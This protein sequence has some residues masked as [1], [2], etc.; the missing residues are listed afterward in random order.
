MHRTIDHVLTELDQVVDLSI[1]QDDA[2]GI[3]A[4]V[5]RRTTAEIK[6]HIE[7]RNF[8]DNERMERFDVVFA[9][10]YLKAFQSWQE[11]QTASDPWRISFEAA[12]RPLCIMQHL[13][14]GMNAHI[15][16]DL[17]LAAAEVAPGEEIFP[18]EADFMKVNDVL[19]SLIDEIQDRIARVS[20]LMFV[21]DRL[22]REDERLAASM[23][24]R[25]RYQA[26]Q[27]ACQLAMADPE[28]KTQLQTELVREVS[29]E[30]NLILHPPHPSLRLG[31]W[32][33]RQFETRKLSKLL[34]RLSA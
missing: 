2:K 23:I 22:S 20:P 28:Q 30:G 8:E 3:F 15:N 32:L 21:V 1:A 12:A 16:L 11:A 5:Y 4:Y 26:W 19:E 18:L 34:E 31:M 25:Y 24:R 13:M 6:R 14:L 10:Y 33:A 9:G 17:S 27:H 7:L 29:Q